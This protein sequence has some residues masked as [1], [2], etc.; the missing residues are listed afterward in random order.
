MKS[1]FPIYHQHDAMDCGPTCLRMVAAY[2]GRK[3][4]LE[5]LREKSHISREGVS[6]LGISEA[7]ENLGFRTIGVK[8]TFEE[9]IKAPHPCIVHWNQNHFIVVYKIRKHKGT[10]SVYVADPAAGK[11]KYTQEEFSRCWTSSVDEKSDV[12]IALL[13]EPT[14][15]FYNH[16][17]EKAEKKGFK[18][19]FSY[20]KPY[21]G[22]IFQLILGLIFGSLLQLIMPF[23]S[24]SIV[25]YGISNQNLSFIWLVLIAQLVLT[26]SSTSVEFIRGW[27]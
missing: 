2:Y 10:Y 23:L 21:K 27:I 4:S 15:D 9:L 8:I 5:G 14:P 13:L 20:L 18:F 24:Q 17:E 22:F 12:G 19:L 7:A 1:P 6:L 16:E 25:D 26:L 3:Y 11:V